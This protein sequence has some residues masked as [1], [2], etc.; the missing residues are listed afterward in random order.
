MT[1]T[2]KATMTDK[3]IFLVEVKQAGIFRI[4]G[5]G[6]DELPLVLEIGCPNVLLP[7]A[8]EVVNDLVT[9]GGF[10]QLMLAPVNFETLYE[11]K[12]NAQPSEAQKQ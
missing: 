3:T 11:Q 9:K 12:H 6:S 7:F 2:A 10:P 4:S 5:I 8:R 1:V